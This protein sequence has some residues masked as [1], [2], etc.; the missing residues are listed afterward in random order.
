V[1]NDVVVNGIL[2]S[3]AVLTVLNP[4]A[5]SIAYLRT[6]VDPVTYQATNVP[7]T[8][9]YQVTGIVT[10]FTNLTTGNTASYYLQDGTGGIN[11]FATL[12]STF[13]P[14]Q[15]DVV[16]FVGVVSSFTSGLEL[17]A[18]TVNRTYTSYTILSNNIAGLPTPIIISFD[19]L[20]NLNN[21][22]YNLGGSLVMI[23]NVYFGANAGTVLSTTANNTIIVT[24]AVGKTFSLFFAFLD[25]DTA[26][27]TLPDYA[28][29][30]TGVLYGTSTNIIVV[31]KFSDIVTNVVAPAPIPLTAVLSG[32]SFALSW[33]DP[34]FSLQ[35]STN[36]AGPYTTIPGATSSYTDQTTNAAGFYRLYHP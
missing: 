15:G 3:N 6:L 33:S 22:N 25:Q 27:Q 19:I 28:K 18:D 21:V 9:P 26:G 34:T 10:T 14:A 12:G 29:S 20:T 36:V 16:T 24:N 5:V 31:T 4:P 17:Y 2:S 23:T 13:R 30:V 7:A 11:I 32:Q 8:L 35:F 1:T